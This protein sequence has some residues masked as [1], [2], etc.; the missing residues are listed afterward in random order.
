[1]GTPC[2][3]PRRCIRS[4]LGRSCTDFPV[5]QHIHE[6]GMLATGK[7]FDLDS[8]RGAPHPRQHP[9]YLIS[10]SSRH[11]LSSGPIHIDAAFLILQL[12]LQ[13]GNRYQRLNA[14][15]ANQ[16]KALCLTVDVISEMPL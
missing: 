16:F 5:H 6:L 3:L 11:S 1:M 15:T 10:K 14:V 12:F 8:L 7:H 2:P 13:L 9:V 4:T